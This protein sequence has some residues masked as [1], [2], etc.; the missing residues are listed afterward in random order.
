MKSDYAL[1][2]RLISINKTRV[3][4]KCHNLCTHLHIYIR[5]Y[6]LGWIFYICH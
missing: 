1:V 6:T 3:A 4:T 2:K 5:L